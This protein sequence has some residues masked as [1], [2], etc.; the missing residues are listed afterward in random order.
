MNWGSVKKSVII[1][2]DLEKAWT[3]ISKIAKLDWL[4]GQKST[5]FLGEKKTGVGA[6][7]L[8]SF[9]DGSKDEEHVVGWKPKE[10]F[11]YIAVSGLPLEAYHA[12]ISIE[13][14]KTKSIKVTWESYFAAKTTK[15]EFDEF[16]EFLSNFYAQSLKNLR[17][18]F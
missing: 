14:N 3:K 6:K 18:K 5:K 12:T 2:T 8:I 11:S 17:E 15:A 1:E 9:E 4:E 13:K 10:Y 7:R 16:V